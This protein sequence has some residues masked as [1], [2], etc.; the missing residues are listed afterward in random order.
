MDLAESQGMK[1]DPN[2]NKKT[3]QMEKKECLQIWVGGVC[4]WLRARM[5][6]GLAEW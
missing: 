2:I 3:P 4:V 1:K 6:N 5:Q